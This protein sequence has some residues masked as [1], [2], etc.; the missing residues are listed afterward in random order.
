[1]LVCYSS[2]HV[3][4]NINSWNV[5]LYSLPQ[6]WCSGRVLASQTRDLGS[7]SSRDRPKSLKQVMTAPLPNAQQ[8]VW[9][10]QVIGDDHYKGLAGV[11]VAVTR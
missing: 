11:K 9:V 3:F 5:L 4:V 10:S 2:L 1:M 6:Q 7:I 8:K